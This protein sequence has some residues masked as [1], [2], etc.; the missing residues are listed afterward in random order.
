[1][2]YI[3]SSSSS[4]LLSFPPQQNQ[5]SEGAEAGGKRSLGGFHLGQDWRRTRVCRQD[6][7]CQ[8]ER[9]TGGMQEEVKMGGGETQAVGGV[10]E[11]R[12]SRLDIQWICINRRRVGKQMQLNLRRL[13]EIRLQV[14]LIDWYCWSRLFSK[15]SNCQLS[16]LRLTPPPRERSQNKSPGF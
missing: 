2:R 13:V 16:G 10:K 6:S 8:L 4:F 12:R 11:K 7:G 3:S 5:L 14:R 9:T 1:M 15:S